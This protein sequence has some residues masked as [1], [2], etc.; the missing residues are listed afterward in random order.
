MAPEFDPAWEYATVD[1]E[2]RYCMSSNAKGNAVEA[3]A[4]F[5]NRGELSGVTVC[6]NPNK[7]NSK[8]PNRQPIEDNGRRKIGRPSKVNLELLKEMYLANEKMSVIAA[9]LG[10]CEAQVRRLRKKVCAE[11]IRPRGRPKKC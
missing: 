9:T 3:L 10:I 4:S 8:S 1:D 7:L 5:Y 2:I 11:A 6:E